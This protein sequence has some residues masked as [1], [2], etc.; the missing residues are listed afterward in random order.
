MSKTEKT[1][2][3]G[4]GSPN[5]NDQLGWLIIDE[6]K[7]KTT[8]PNLTFF[9][10]KSNGSDWFH[11]INDHQQIIFI[12]AVL[13]EEPIGSLIEVSVGDLDQL[14]SN[15]SSSHNISLAD[16]LSLARSLDYLDA[17]VRII[18][19]SIEQD[20]HVKKI[21]NE[22]KHIALNFRQKFL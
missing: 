17:V 8:Q 20:N 6:L 3:V 2:I 16:S 11:E 7:Q 13:S 1:L 4:L 21:K 5:G 15:S 18:G 22:L 14:S 12:D 9:K 10:S 19:I